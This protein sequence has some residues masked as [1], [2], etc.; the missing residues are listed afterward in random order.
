MADGVI[1]RAAAAL[2]SVPV[3]IALVV[4]ACGGAGTASTTPQPSAS[5]SAS[6]APTFAPPS[7]T[8]IVLPSFAQVSAPSADVVWMLVAGTRLF[9]STDRGGA[10]DERSIPT[11]ARNPVVSFVSAREGWLAT[12]EP[13]ASACQTQPSAIWH[14]ADAAASWQQ[15]GP[16]GITAAAC[17]GSLS[18]SDEHHGFVAALDQR[19]G[20]VVYRTADGGKT[21]TSSGSLADPPGLP[22]QGGRA[23]L[24]LGRVRAFGPTLLVGATIPAPSGPSTHVYRSLDSGA[25]WMYAAAIPTAGTLAI[26]TASRW[27]RIGPAGGSFESL[28]AGTTWHAYPTDYSQAAPVAPEI[29]FGDASIGYATVRGGLQRTVDGGAHWTTLITPGT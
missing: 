7:A 15:V 25:T 1:V 24:Q 29:V 23:D 26:V 12:V 20:P 2:R 19:S 6:A 3:L 11:L 18:F 10:W 4:A 9:R 21:W 28:D 16:S 8:P 14:T 13:S 27:L 22:M 17:N 5:P